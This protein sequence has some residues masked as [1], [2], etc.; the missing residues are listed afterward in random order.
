MTQRGYFRIFCT[1]FGMCVIDTK[2]AMRQ[3]LAQPH[4][5][6]NISIKHVAGAIANDII[7][8]MNLT[9]ETRDAYSIPALGDGPPGNVQVSSARASDSSSVITGTSP[10]GGSIASS[11]ASSSLSFSWIVSMLSVGAPPGIPEY[12]REGRR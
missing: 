5:L 11:A 3:G 2:E 8:R 1:I 6:A 9:D 10:A 7:R 12:Y 4:P